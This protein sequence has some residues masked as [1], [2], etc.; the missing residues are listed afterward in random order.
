MRILLAIDLYEC[1]NRVR[2]M[3]NCLILLYYA[4]TFLLSFS[5]S[6]RNTFKLGGSLF[7]IPTEYYKYREKELVQN[8]GSTLFKKKRQVNYG[9]DTTNKHI[10]LI[11]EK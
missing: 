5:I 4:H 11:S 3:I 2:F 1:A 7:D 8:T 10:C 6:V 9:D